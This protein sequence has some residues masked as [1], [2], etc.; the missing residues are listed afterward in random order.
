MKRIYKHIKFLSLFIAILAT[1]HVMPSEPKLIIVNKTM[2]KTNC[3]TKITINEPGE[4]PEQVIDSKE[5][6]IRPLILSLNTIRKLTVS[7]PGEYLHLLGTSAEI[8]LQTEK[9]KHPKQNLLA[10]ITYQSGSA[11]TLWRGSWQVTIK[12][13]SSTELAHER[14]IHPNPSFSK[15]LGHLSLAGLLA[16]D[17]QF[18][19][20]IWSNFTHA[21]AK[22][23]EGNLAVQAYNVFN[24]PKESSKLTPNLNRQLDQ[25]TQEILNNAHS[26]QP[27]EKAAVQA[28]LNIALAMLQCN[29]L[30]ASIDVFTALPFNRVAYTTLSDAP[31]ASAPQPAPSTIAP[32]TIPSVSAPKES[33][34]QPS[35]KTIAVPPAPQIVGLRKDAETIEGLE[36]TATAP[37]ATA[38]TTGELLGTVPKKTGPA[39]GFKAMKAAREGTIQDLFEKLKERGATPELESVVPDDLEQIRQNFNRNLQAR[40]HKSTP[41][42]LKQ[43][44][45]V[46]AALDVIQTLYTELAEQRISILSKTSREPRALNNITSCISFLKILTTPI[47]D[48]LV[49]TADTDKGLAL[50][51]MHGLFSLNTDQRRQLLAIKDVST[52][53]NTM[54]D[55]NETLEELVPQLRQAYSRKQ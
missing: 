41:E 49:A 45:T 11:T 33:S 29:R 15:V 39:K 5:F 48:L 55:L 20:N 7:T 16:N 53:L 13:L 44:A 12:P 24:L 42:Q 52:L 2:C 38:T 27:T 14:I 34:T 25:L 37:A 1:R 8:N 50:N 32:Q 19:I 54:E 17:V 43:P 26:L 51:F 30:D 3:P 4:Y 18:L 31:S 36:T 28:I 40:S 23:A 10:E 21:F 47:V 22:I 35:V 46:D 6:T 9:D